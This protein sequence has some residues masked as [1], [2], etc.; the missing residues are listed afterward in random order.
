MQFEENTNVKKLGE[1]VGFF[2]SFFLFSSILYLILS[3]LHKI[4]TYVKYIHVVTGVILVYF[5]GLVLRR[6]FVR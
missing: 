6:L 1:N 2:V 5:L 4:P 3:L